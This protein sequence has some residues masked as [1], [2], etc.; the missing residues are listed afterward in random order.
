MSTTQ[1]ADL[2]I[3]HL[4]DA[5]IDLIIKLQDLPGHFEDHDDEGDSE[6][7]FDDTE[8]F[9]LISAKIELYDTVLKAV[10]K[11]YG[12]DYDIPVSRFSGVLPNLPNIPFETTVMKNKVGDYLFKMESSFNLFVK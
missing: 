8:D 11:I 9:R 5:Q 1:E 12:F 6:F 10:A 2:L 3:K 7:V 4:K